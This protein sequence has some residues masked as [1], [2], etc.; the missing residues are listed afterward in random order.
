MITFLPSYQSVR[1]NIQEDLNLYQHNCQNLKSDTV[2]RFV[3]IL[4]LHISKRR[5]RE[6]QYACQF[7]FASYFCM[8]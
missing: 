5:S 1:N 6:G 7:L 4:L 2:L 8:L 3:P